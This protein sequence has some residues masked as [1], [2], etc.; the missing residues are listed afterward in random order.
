MGGTVRVLEALGDDHPMRDKFLALHRR[1]AE[2]II[3]LQQP[4]GLWRSSL[5]DPEEFPTPETSGSAFFTYALAWGINHGTLDRETYLPHVIR[6]WNALAAKVDEQ[7]KLTHVQRVA[8][9]PGKVNPQDTHEYAVGALL[10]AGTEV[11]KLAK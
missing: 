7:G 6:G 4:D 10:L 11:A 5:L 3:S 8:G 2:V 9:A 1:M